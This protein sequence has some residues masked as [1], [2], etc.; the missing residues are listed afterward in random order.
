MDPDETLRLLREAYSRFE[1]VRGAES[2]PV[3]DAASDMRDAVVALDEWL[4]RGGFLP[5]AWRR[6]LGMSAEQAHVLLDG[7]TAVE[8]DIRGGAEPW[9]NYNTDAERGE[10]DGLGS[11]VGYRGALAAGQ[12]VLSEIVDRG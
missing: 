9:E 12:A 7:V 4:S 10:G 11:A 6:S 2:G 3:V 1:D 5:A 8:K